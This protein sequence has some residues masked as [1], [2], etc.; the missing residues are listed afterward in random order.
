MDWL[1]KTSFTEESFSDHMRYYIVKD[2]TPE[3]K[4][5]ISRADGES[6]AIYIT[7]TLQY[8]SG[9]TDAD[10]V[11]ITLYI[12]WFSDAYGRGTS[13]INDLVEDTI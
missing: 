11:G 10:D 3:D 8:L 6:G 2:L 1:D 5:I 12:V 4:C 13:S 7:V 9:G